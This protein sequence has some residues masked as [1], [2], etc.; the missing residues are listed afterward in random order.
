MKQHTF[1]KPFFA[2]ASVSILLFASS[3]SKSDS[4][5]SGGGTT[6]DNRGVTSLPGGG[7]TTGIGGSYAQF[8]IVGNFLYAIQNQ[9]L[10]VYSLL[11][12][13]MPVLK[14]NMQLPR[15]WNTEIETIFSYKN[16]LLFGTTTGVL[17]YSLDNPETPRFISEMTHVTACDPVVAEADIAYVTLNSEMDCRGNINQLD[18]LDISNINSPRLITSVNMTAPRGLGIDDKALF[19]CDGNRL[20]V[21]D[22]TVSNQPLLM[23]S[24]DIERPY[25]C[26]PHNNN[27]IVSAA[28]GLY[29]FNY[30]DPKS[31]KFSSKIPV[32]K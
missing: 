6:Q 10:L 29:Q 16:N 22:V 2:I 13:A 7:G 11:D 3:C 26:I 12:L 27:L 1:Y 30:Q 9:N 23:S 8:T 19:V 20:L 25:D 5:M 18:I 14:T 31:I 17:F 28:D 15:N 32:E 4:D 24:F 21:Y